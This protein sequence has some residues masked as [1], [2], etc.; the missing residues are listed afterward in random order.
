LNFALPAAIRDRFATVKT[1]V[2]HKKSFYCT[3]RWNSQYA[4]RSLFL[5]NMKHM[6]K[7]GKSRLSPNA[8]QNRTSKDWFFSPAKLLN[9]R[10]ATKLSSCSIAR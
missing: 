2:V 4:E 5:S 9:F 10:A 3:T 7:Q 6:K 8:R 1:S